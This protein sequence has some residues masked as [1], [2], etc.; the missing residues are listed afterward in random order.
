M[1]ASPSALAVAPDCR[2]ECERPADPFAA[3]ELGLILSGDGLDP[4]EAFLDFLADA[5][6]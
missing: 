4:A 1:S 2:G 3:P 5:L 6:A